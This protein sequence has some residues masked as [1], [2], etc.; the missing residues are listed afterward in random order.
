MVV[1]VIA[2]EIVTRTGIEITASTDGLRSATAGSEWYAAIT[3]VT[4]FGPAA[5]CAYIIET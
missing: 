4:A 5:G 1:T 3:H 2:A